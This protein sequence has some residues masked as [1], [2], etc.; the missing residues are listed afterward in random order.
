MLDCFCITFIN[1]PVHIL[2]QCWLWLPSIH[3]PWISRQYHPFPRQLYTQKLVLECI[4]SVH[5][6]YWLSANIPEK[7]TT[8]E[9]SLV[10]QCLRLLAHNERGLGSIPGQGT[11]F[12][13]PQLRVCIPQKRSKILRATTNTWHSQINKRG[14]SL[15]IQWLRIFLAI[16]GTQVWSLVRELRP[17]I[18]QGT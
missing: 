5:M 1:I 16:Q 14:T 8:C 2:L 9:I 15:V 17:H 10:V 7:N 3:N 12:H 11:I 4:T 6:L 18:L 13:M